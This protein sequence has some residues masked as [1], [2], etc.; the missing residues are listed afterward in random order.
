MIKNN[1]KGF[2]LIGYATSPMG[3]GE[4]LRT[5]AAMLDYLDIP[6]S[7]IDVPTE[8]QGRVSYQWKNLKTDTFPISIFFMSASACGQLGR[9]HPKLFSEPKLKIGNSML[10]EQIH[11]LLLRIMDKTKR[12]NVF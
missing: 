6:F 7:V 1:K 8:V 12:F 2:N 3:L 5:F 4:D 9:L 11:N 10:N